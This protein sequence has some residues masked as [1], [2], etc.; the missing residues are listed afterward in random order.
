MDR[1][2]I[3][4][5]SGSD[6]RSEKEHPPTAVNSPP[7][8]GEIGATPKEAVANPKPSIP[9]RPTGRVVS[10]EEQRLDYF[11]YAPMRS[12]NRLMDALYH[13]DS[14]YESA[15]YAWVRPE[16]AKKLFLYG[17]CKEVTKT[18]VDLMED[19]E[20]LQDT[21]DAK[22]PER[23]AKLVIGAITDAQTYRIRKMVELLSILILFDRTATRDE[24]YR[25]FLNAESLDLE[26]ARLEDFRELYGGRIIANTRHSV[27]GFADRI[28]QDLEA[29]GVSS[30]WFINPGNLK[31]KRPSVFA[32]KRTLYL[33][34]L[35]AA[36]PDER[37]AL[38]IS[39]GRG[40]SRA[41][42]SVHPLIGSH[43]YGRED[44]DPRHMRVNFTY[45]GIITMHIIRLAHKL[46]GIDDPDGID[47]I[48][49]ANF[50]KSE[51]SK[52]I[53]SFQKE[54]EVGD[55][56]LTAWT[57][58]VEVLETHTSKYGYRAYRV[59]FI[60]RAH[61]PEIPEDWL[62]SQGILLRLM[63]KSAIRDV[64]E[65]AMASEKYS[66]DDLDSM[67]EV[68]KLPDEKLIEYAGKTFLEMHRAGVLIPLL[69]RQGYLK[70]TGT[71]GADIE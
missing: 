44:N 9:V 31:K 23:L 45:L 3:V 6:H 5:P 67:A 12:A 66:K 36:S 65:K 24:E 62:E 64:C 22:N 35:L 38:G 42:Q 56:V 10:E 55:I 20:H 7:S 51:A 16:D 34:A 49:G 46:A 60:S 70:R 2:Q 17:V 27:D 39:Y 30:L 40:Y 26:L 18:C 69:V 8:D 57:D 41:S 14:F 32:S 53:R 13:D 33:Q 15:T 4:P 48:V 19:K 68:L 28:R 63:P 50:E 54:F 71:A 61:I 58:I 37:I 25:V 11:V 59:K 43:D 47:K 21:P 1:D 29:L 52:A